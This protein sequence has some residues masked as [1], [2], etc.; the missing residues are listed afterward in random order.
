M[1]RIQGTKHSLVMRTNGVSKHLGIV[2]APSTQQGMLPMTPD[3][4]HGT[5]RINNWIDQQPVTSP[6]VDLSIII[7]AYNEERR[8][9]PTLIDVIDFFDRKAISYEV[10]VIDDGSSDGTAEVVRKFERVRN[11]VRLIQLPRNYGKGHAVRLGVLNCRGSRILFADADGA[12]P[13]QECERLEAALSTGADVAIGSRALASTET[14]VAT[15][16]HRRFLGRVFNRCVNMILLPSIADTQCGFKMFTR[17]AAL[18]L[19]RR[20]RADRFSFDVELLYMAHKAQLTIKEVPINW[21]NVPGS[22]VNLVVDSLSMFRDVFR[23]RVIH[24]GI[25]RACFDQFEEQI[26]ET[27]NQ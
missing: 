18:F 11:Q 10:V 19:F 26:A 14:K 7:P 25:D 5:E 3:T 24:R 17:K 13:I 12:T 20:Q 27:A 23:F 15:S 8:L 22:K 21:T 1:L 2:Y 6:Q 9:P 4:A 16:L